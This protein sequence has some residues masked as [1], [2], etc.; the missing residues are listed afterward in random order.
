VL[1]VDSE[2]SLQKWE[3]QVLEVL[4][5]SFTARLTDRS[6]RNGKEDAEL[7]FS[8]VSSD[9]MPLLKP[10]AIFYWTIGRHTDSTNR[11]RILSELRFRR[12]PTWTEEEVI[13][14]SLEAQRLATA[15]GIE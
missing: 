13:Q 6:A 7:S 10:G 15:F 11:P 1:A 12:L 2:I 8:E 4:H 14:A 3:G 5:D 9:D